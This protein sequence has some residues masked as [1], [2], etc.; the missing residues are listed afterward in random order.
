MHAEWA[1]GREHGLP[2]RSVGRNQH[3]HVRPRRVLP[4]RPPNSRS[5]PPSR[6]WPTW[7]VA[8][9]RSPPAAKMD[10]NPTN[11]VHSALPLRVSRGNSCRASRNKVFPDTTPVAATHR[12][13]GQSRQSPAIRHPRLFVSMRPFRRIHHTFSIGI[14]DFIRI[15]LI[16]SQSCG[17]AL[18]GRGMVFHSSVQLSCW[19]G[20][21]SSR[22]GFANSLFR[23][24][25]PAGGSVEPRGGCLGR[26]F[27]TDEKSAGRA[28]EF[29]R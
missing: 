10:P 23:H 11:C 8:T 21:G 5:A 28:R 16:T 15:F 27:I 26:A 9:G 24:R 3:A 4:A 2:P 18:F 22:H 29:F 17:T 13:S 7:A 12:V 6:P 1:A 25:L 20:T 19:F 14:L